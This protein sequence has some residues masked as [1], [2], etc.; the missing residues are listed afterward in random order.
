MNKLI[1]LIKNKPILSTLIL[2]IITGNLTD[3]PLQNYLCKFMPY[4]ASLMLSIFIVQIGSFGLC[5]YV[6][7]K[8]D[9]SNTLN[10]SLSKPIKDLWITIPFLVL[11]LSNCSLLL[12]AIH[13]SLTTLISL[14]NST[15]S[16][17]SF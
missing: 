4:P 11:I 2:I 10:M 8:L 15:F 14:L 1:T 6:I 13:S 9:F 3:I 7:H 16:I 17:S 5:I 12:Y